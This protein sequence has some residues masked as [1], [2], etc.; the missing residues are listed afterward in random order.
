MWPF[1]ETITQKF[2]GDNKKLI[3]IFILLVIFIGLAI[4]VYNTYISTMVDPNY[5]ENNE[6]LSKDAKQYTELYFFHTTWCPHCKKAMPIWEKIK[7]KYNNKVMND[8]V[9]IFKDVNGDEEE[10]IDDF[11]KKYKTEI[12]GYPTILMV[13]KDKILEY[14]G[15]PNYTSLSKFVETKL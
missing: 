12:D 4:Y 13:Q 2:R 11:E 10:Y 6:F 7:G 1:L 14:D 9:L 8:S 15:K 5:V 3:M